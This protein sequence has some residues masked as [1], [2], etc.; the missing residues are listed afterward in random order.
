MTAAPVPWSSKFL[1]FF[2]FFLTL[3]SFPGIRGGDRK[4]ARRTGVSDA[5]KRAEKKAFG[6]AERFPEPSGAGGG[7]VGVSL[8][9]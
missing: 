3:G 5:T 8:K 9:R 6:E 7:S 1:V 4:G 2:F